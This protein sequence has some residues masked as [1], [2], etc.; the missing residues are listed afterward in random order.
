[1]D[2]LAQSAGTE[3]AIEVENLKIRYKCLQKM[4]IKKK[5]HNFEKHFI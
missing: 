1:M 3:Y 2:G 5:L 4:S